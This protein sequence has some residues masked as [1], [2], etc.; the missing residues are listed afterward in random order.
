MNFTLA[1]VSAQADKAPPPFAVPS[2]F[3]I[4]TP[5]RPTES[6]KALA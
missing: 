3:V 4:I 6:L 5:E 1:P 2:N